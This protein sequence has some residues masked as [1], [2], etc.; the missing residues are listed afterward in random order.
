MPLDNKGIHQYTETD[1]AISFS[2]ML[3]L[4]M[5]SVSDSLAYFA[6]SSAKRL[7][8]EPAPPGARWKDTD[9]SELLYSAG[10]DGAWRQH[11]GSTF[12][13]GGPWAIGGVN[14]SLVMYARTVT[15]DIPTVL[16]PTE[17]LSIV[18]YDS[19]STYTWASIASTTKHANRTT[20]IVRQY[21]FGSSATPNLRFTWQVTTGAS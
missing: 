18:A 17:T 7:A 15:L 6:G 16:G 8:L 1:Q 10:P 4:G 2:E 13:A 3:N 14:G 11:E 5:Q 21:I 12:V 9:G 20:L 19:T